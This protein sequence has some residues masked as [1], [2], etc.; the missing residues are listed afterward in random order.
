MKD[1]THAT[2]DLPIASRP[3][4]SPATLRIPDNAKK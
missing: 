3:W 2:N 4:T 1:D